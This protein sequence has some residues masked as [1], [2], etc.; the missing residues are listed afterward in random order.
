[1]Y[2]IFQIPDYDKMQSKEFNTYSL[3]PEKFDNIL[4]RKGRSYSKL[5]YLNN[6]II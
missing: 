6:I 2:F 4:S 3:D 1:M 5:K